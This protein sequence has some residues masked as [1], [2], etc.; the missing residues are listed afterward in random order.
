MTPEHRAGTEFRVSG[1]TLSGVAMPYGTVSPDYRE[2]FV[3]G[4]F[5]EV[6][7]IPVNLQHDSSIV[8]APEAL[9]TDTPR[10]LR[11][12]AELPEGSA[13]LKLVRRGVLNGFSIEFHSRAERREA[14]VRVI[15][16]AELV[17]LALV[18]AGAYPGSFAEVRAR[19]DRG[20]RLGTLRG[21]VPADR[22]LACRCS[23]GDCTEA[24]FEAGALDGTLDRDEVLAV[25]G[26]YANA[27]ASKRRGGVR[28]WIGEAGSLEYAI[29]V[30]NTARGA[31]LMETMDSVPVYGRPVINPDASDVTIANQ[32]ATYRRADVRAITVGATDA[33]QG[34][35]PLRPK[36]GDDDDQPARREAPKPAPEVAERLIWL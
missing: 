23:P 21:R 2:R 28:F 4:A 31:A 30:P 25:V 32:V 36:R 7:T 24:L 8:V 16:R 34:W 26:E 11:V 27:I 14:G 18:D 12:R 15:A 35:D 20:G 13:A 5:G 1:R 3:P 17:G 33:D 22:L 10:E 9:L 6:S 29:D 19:G